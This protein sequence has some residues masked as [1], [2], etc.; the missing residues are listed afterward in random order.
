MFTLHNILEIMLV[1]LN[2]VVILGMMYFG[3]LLLG[4]KTVDQQTATFSNQSACRKILNEQKRRNLTDYFWS[5]IL[6]VGW[7]ILVLTSFIAFGYIM[8]SDWS[9]I[10]SILSFILLMGFAYFAYHSYINFE[11]KAKKALTE[12]ERVIKEGFEKESRFDGD[13]IQRFSHDDQEMDTES[14][15]YYF[16]DGISK[17][18]FPPFENRGGKKPILETRTME[19]LILSREYFSIC[20]GA[21]PF[22]LFEPKRGGP[23]CKLVRSS[24]ECNEYYYSQMRNVAYTDGAIQIIFGHD[25]KPVNFTCKKGDA[26]AV[27]K[28]LKEKLRITE[29]QRLRKMEEHEQ[30]E[31]ILDRRLRKKSDH[32]DDQNPTSNKEEE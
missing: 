31:E 10:L 24:G 4:K 19:C 8:D 25:E 28:A 14:K 20:K 15:P 7:V 3:W 2:T 26:G 32:N 17:V 18:P 6:R 22:N 27:M 1:I 21:T 11:E 16:Y 23:Q 5:D 30:Y 9:Y 29:R 13:N 12:H